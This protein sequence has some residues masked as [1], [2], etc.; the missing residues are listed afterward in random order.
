MQLFK[1]FHLALL[2]GCVFRVW[3]AE[4]VPYSSPGVPAADYNYRM[5][6]IQ[7]EDVLV[8]GGDKRYVVKGF[9]GQG[10][11]TLVLRAVKEGSA[12]E[13]ALRVPL[14]SGY[15]NSHLMDSTSWAERRKRLLNP[16]IPGAKGFLKAQDEIFGR[17]N[18]KNLTY[19]EFLDES[20][21]S[22]FP[23]WKSGFPVVRP[24]DV[25]EREF[26]AVEI[27]GLHKETAK[28][29]LSLREY[30]IRPENLSLEDQDP[31]LRSLAN[32][33]DSF[34]NVSDLRDFG[35]RQVLWDPK[36][37]TWEIGDLVTAPQYMKNLAGHLASIDKRI[38]MTELADLRE[39]MIKNEYP[40]K[41][42]DE[43][44]GMVRAIQKKAYRDRG[45]FIGCSIF[46]RR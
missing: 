42:I 40:T 45:G 26:V 16:S 21:K 10:N 36:S 7:P 23:T 33:A 35:L 27:L 41:M 44:M 25:G 9:L 43:V 24:L 34:F 32:L 8:F 38:L 39:E 6:A 28:E 14:F 37:K 18:N 11:T 46:G 3:A 29:V 15:F 13:V 20:S 22:W 4:Y 5:P 12:E 31:A 17:E 30:L 2:L 1:T 19:Q